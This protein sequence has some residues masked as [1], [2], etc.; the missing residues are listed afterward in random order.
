MTTKIKYLG[1]SAVALTAGLALAP[2]ASA[3]AIAVANLDNAVTKTTAFVNATNQINTQ[4]KAQLDQADAIAK[5]ELPLLSSIDTDKDGQLSDQ[6]VANAQATKN[7]ALAQLTQ[8][9][10]QRRQLMAPAA[11]AQQYALEQVSAK[12]QA[13]YATVKANKKISLLI[14]PE[15]VYDA[16]ANADVTPDIT[17]ELN[18]LVPSVSITPPAGWQPGGKSAPAAPAAS[19]PLP[20]G[21]PAGP[22]VPA[23]APAPGKKPAGR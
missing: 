7:P 12:L 16:D 15:A 18:K 21:V 13:A 19:G 17:A 11:R 6:E 14:R 10:T 3:Q 4:Y 2:Q 9:E 22:S 23:P 5:E 1:I 20:S 8:K